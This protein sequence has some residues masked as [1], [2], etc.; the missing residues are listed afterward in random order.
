MNLFAQVAPHKSNMV[1]LNPIYKNFFE[2]TEPRALINNRYVYDII[3][4]E[5]ISEGNI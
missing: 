4:N 1:S 2:N 5:D 3:F